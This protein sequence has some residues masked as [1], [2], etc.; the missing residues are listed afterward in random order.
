VRR[1]LHLLRKEYPS[2]AAALKAQE[3][4]AREVRDRMED[5]ERKR[6]EVQKALDKKIQERDTELKVLSKYQG[7]VSEI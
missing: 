3:E 5:A 6:G 7:K 2:T 4:A 1:Q